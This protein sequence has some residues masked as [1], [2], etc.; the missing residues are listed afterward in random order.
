MTQQT[1]IF[2]K[3]GLIAQLRLLAHGTHDTEHNQQVLSA[4]ARQLGGAEM[5][6]EEKQP[7]PAWRGQQDA[8]GHRSCCFLSLESQ[9]HDQLMQ[10]QRG[11]WF[12][13]ATSQC[14]AFPGFHCDKHM[15]GINLFCSL[16]SKL[17]VN[18]IC[19][20]EF[21]SQRG[22]GLWCDAESEAPGQGEDAR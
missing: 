7:D 16:A 13:K 20:W 14:Q 22:Q 12:L 19:Q 6:Q 15:D 8:N 17:R 1:E 18:F 5:E 4:V 10:V 21:I 11:K 9:V 3:W 2:A